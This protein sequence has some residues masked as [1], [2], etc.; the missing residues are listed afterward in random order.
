M[1]TRF[2]PAVEDRLVKIRVDSI[3]LEGDLNIPSGAEAIVLF[4]HGSGSRR[5]SK[6]N[7]FVARTLRQGS[8]ATLLMNLLTPE[9]ER[10]DVRTRQLRFDIGMLA[11]RLVAAVDWLVTYPDTHGLSIGCFGS[12]TGAAAA[13]IAAKERPELIQAVVSR[14]G[15]PDLAAEILDH[16]TAPT[17]L[18]VGGKDSRVLTLN[19]EALIRLQTEKKLEILPGSTHLFEEPG[20]LDKAAI[21]ARQWFERHLKS[22]CL[23]AQTG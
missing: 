1:S 16:V 19:E 7:R 10:I 18:I 2:V 20:A 14:G 21:L 4:A 22:T 11:A 9:E 15:R 23:M 8:L 12:S 5:H 6:R 13:L 17:L 3:V